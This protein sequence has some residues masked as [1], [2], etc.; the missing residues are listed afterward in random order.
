MKTP[1]H[2]TES[3]RK[4]DEDTPGVVIEVRDSGIMAPDMLN[5]RRILIASGVKVTYPI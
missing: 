4:P 1:T 5:R 3:V 2:P